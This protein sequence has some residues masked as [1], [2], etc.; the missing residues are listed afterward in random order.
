MKSFRD[1]ELWQLSMDLVLD[2]YRATKEFPN[3][4]K[5]G[6]MSQMQRAAVSIPS[7]IAEGS[8]RRNAKEFIQFLYIAKGSLAELETQLELCYRLHYLQNLDCFIDKAKRIRMMLIG[9]L[10]SLSRESTNGNEKT[11][12]R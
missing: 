11:P 5:F 10:A 3:S 12:K 8:G 2:V 1:L 9:L 4:E 7:N 6:I